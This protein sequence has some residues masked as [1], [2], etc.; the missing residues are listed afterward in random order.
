MSTLRSAREAPEDYQ[1][2]SRRN[3]PDQD[4]EI[5]L[6][7]STILLIFFALALVCS[8]FFGFGYTMGRKTMPPAAVAASE[9]HTDSLREAFKAFKPAPGGATASRTNATPLTS[10]QVDSD[11][12]TPVVVPA[13]SAKNVSPPPPKKA[14]DPDAEIV[15]EAPTPKSISVAKPTVAVPVSAAAVSTGT[16]IVQVAA[17]SHQEDADTMLAALKRK[18]YSV[19]IH[20]E[21]QDRLLHLQLGPYASKKDAEAMRTRLLADGYNSILK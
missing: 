7:T 4:R 6:N 11:S 5:S 10:T 17:V 1:N 14:F 13:T 20:Q 15:T 19:S 12:L 8:A 18:G 21:S 3:D 16:F 2:M 9:D